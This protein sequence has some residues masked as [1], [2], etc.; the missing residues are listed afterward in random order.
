MS[1]GGRQ[2]REPG[3]RPSTGGACASSSNRL[4]RSRTAETS[5]KGSRR[6]IFI[7]LCLLQFYVFS[8]TVEPRTSVPSTFQHL[9][10]TRIGFMRK[11]RAGAVE[12]EGAPLARLGYDHFR[13]APGY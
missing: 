11:G 1:T 2:T 4:I 6:L 9:P 7:V 12:L 8:S 13:G 5:E 10:L 3:A